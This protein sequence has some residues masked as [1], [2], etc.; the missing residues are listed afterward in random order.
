MAQIIV[1]PK[2]QRVFAQ[3]LESF[4]REIRDRER[5]LDAGMQELGGTWKDVRYK[6]FSRAV[7]DASVQLQIFYN[8][9][10]RY[11]DFLRRKATAAE[12]FLRL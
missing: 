2:D 6:D 3:E 8:T 5:R 1:N 12:K 10:T 4:V 9:S 11:A 7:T